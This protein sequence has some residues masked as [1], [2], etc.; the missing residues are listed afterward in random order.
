MELSFPGSQVSANTAFYHLNT[1]E[2]D[3]MHDKQ[4]FISQEVISVA[5][6]SD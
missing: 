5:S 4:M 3:F 2:S 1:L 6:L